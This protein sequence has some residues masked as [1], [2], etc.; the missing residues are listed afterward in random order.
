MKDD[1]KKSIVIMV[2]NIVIMVCNS[3][4]AMLQPTKEIA[5][6]VLSNMGVC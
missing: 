2:I 1:N 5:M 6:S 4:L 3:I